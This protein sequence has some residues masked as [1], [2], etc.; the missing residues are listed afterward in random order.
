MQLVIT[1]A[2]KLDV[3]DAAL[4]LVRLYRTHKDERV[5][6]MALVTIHTINNDWAAGIV[7]RDYAFEKSNKIKNRFH[8]HD[9]N[10]ISP[11]F[12]KTIMLIQW[13]LSYVKA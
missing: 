6:Q 8:V 13:D 12:C 1:Y 3:S 4:D 10:I 7:K 9:I 11:P 2:D 5:R